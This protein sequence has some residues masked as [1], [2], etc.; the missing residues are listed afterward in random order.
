MWWQRLLCLREEVEVIAETDGILFARHSQPYAW[1]GK[2]IGKI[3]GACRWLPARAIYSPINSA[4]GRYLAAAQPDNVAYPRLPSFG[5]R[6][7]NE[8]YCANCLS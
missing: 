2:V 4:E 6:N 7:G 3:A 8:K 5:V 1:Q